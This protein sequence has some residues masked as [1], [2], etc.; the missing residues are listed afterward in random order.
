MMPAPQPSADPRS[1]PR[2][3]AR[4]GTAPD[5]PLLMIGSILA[6]TYEMRG[7][8]GS[9]GMAQVF[10]AH[11]LRLDRRVAVKVARP[12]ASEALR[13]EGRTIAALKDSCIVSVL[14]AGAHRGIDYRVMEHISGGSLRAYLDE[15]RGQDTHSIPTTVGLLRAIAEALAVVHRAGLS[16][17][18]LKPEN[19]ML[20]PGDR[21]VLTDFGTTRPEV[22]Q[23]DDGVS[24]SPDYM[25][26]E[27]ILRSVKRGA[28]HLVDLYALG[29]VAYE[30]LVGRTPFER[31]HWSQTLQAHLVEPPRD[32]RDL[33]SD[34][35]HA[36]AHL[37]LELLAKEPH[38][39]PES[40]ETVAWSLR[41]VPTSGRAA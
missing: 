29:I 32:P 24:G 10:E 40:A 25:A 1:A 30:L 5:L 36:L 12:A 11:D 4:P 35:P 27:V 15:P 41:C 34:M 22:F 13:A 21:I 18:D 23:S 20:A 17:R 38:E 33:R 26:R 6:E 8:L 31:E 19:V 7:L 16:H 28:G 2:L 37:V 39:R 3:G 9:G 14:H